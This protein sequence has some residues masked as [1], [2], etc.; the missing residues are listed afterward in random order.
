MKSLVLIILTSLI[1]GSTHTFVQTELPT[2][3]QGTWKMENREIYEHWELVDDGSMKGHSY[4]VN[5]GEKMV[6]ENLEIRL[7]GDKV[8]YTA[9]VLNQNEGK[10]IEFTLNLS[11]EDHT[12]SFENP[13]HDFPKVIIMYQ[14]RSDT[15][16][17]VK[18]SDGGERGFAYV[19]SKVD[20]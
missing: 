4:R 6:T 1:F 9:T 13:D 8:I 19:M 5:N 14:K 3:L 10:G 2:F 20:E 12:Y 16:I 18:V 11:E 15:E 17:Y 7:V